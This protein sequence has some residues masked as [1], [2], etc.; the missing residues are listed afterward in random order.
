[1]FGFLKKKLKESVEK[2]TKKAESKEPKV[3][4]KKSEA[5]EKPVKKVEVS[6]YK[7]SKKVKE[8]LEEVEKEVEHIEGEQVGISEEEEPLESLSEDE[9]KEEVAEEE[10]EEELESAKEPI[11]EP[12]KVEPEEKLEEELH[13]KIEPK[14]KKGFRGFFKEPFGKRFIK[15][16]VEK[17]LSGKDIEDFFG[18]LESDLLEANVALEVVDF[19]KDNLK[20]RLVGKELKRGKVE[21]EI[22]QAFEE[23]LLKI[24]N[25]GEVDLD[26]KKLLLF[27]GY[28]GAGKTTSIAKVAYYLK[29]KNKKVVLA[30]GDTFRAASIEQLQVHGDRLGVNV[31]KH[32]YGSDSAAVIFDAVKHAEAKRIDYVLADT[33]GRTHTNT[34]LVDELKKVCRVNKPDLKV[35]IIDSLT[36]NDAVEQAREFDQAVGVDAVMFTKIDVNEKGGAVLSVSH[37]I[38]KPILFLGTGQDYKDIIRFEPTKFVKELLE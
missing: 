20:K 29:E 31:I 7:P 9:I 37:A 28:N 5:K 30:A 1:M 11:A 38:K 24:V 32:K 33:A 19:L 13:I 34:N 4:I 26:K 6:K 17:E 14:E 23:S 3:E 18:D 22:K 21:Q 35:L 36:G 12:T 27:L 8:E 2:L 25:Q 15:K 16:L 10:S